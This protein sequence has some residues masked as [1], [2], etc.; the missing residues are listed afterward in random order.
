MKAAFWRKNA[1][2]SKLKKSSICK[3]RSD[4]VDIHEF[5]SFR[6]YRDRASQ[7]CL[8]DAIYQLNKRYK[9]APNTT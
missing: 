7:K 2:K 8:I 5:I 4:R 9:R 6:N 1:A 3:S